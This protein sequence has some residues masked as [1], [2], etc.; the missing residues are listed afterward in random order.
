LEIVDSRR[1][2][3]LAFALTF[4]CCLPLHAAIEVSLEPGTP[5]DSLQ[6]ARDQVRALRKAGQ[7][8]HASIWVEH[9]IFQ[10]T[11]TVTFEAQDSDI[12]IRAVDSATPTFVGAAVVTGFTPHEG[13]IM[14]ADICALVAKGAKYRQVLFGGERL[15]LAR[16]PNFDA[17]DPLYGGWAF[18]EDIPKT[19]LEKHSWKTELYVKPQ[20]LRT[21][22]HPEEVE[23]DIFA[24]YGWWNFI[25][26]VKSLDAT[27]RKLTLA[28]PC[29][30]DLHPHNRFHFQNA[31]E[32]LDAP[33]EF[34]IDPRSSILYIM[35]PEE[36]TKREVRLVT[37][38]SFIKFSADAKNI[39]IERLKFTGCNS[40]AVTM[41]N[42]KGCRIAGC[43]FINVGDFNGSAIGISGGYDNTA[44]GNDISYT[45]SN[46]IS[47]SGG[48]RPTLTACNNTA[49]NNHIHHIGVFNKNA[50]GVSANGVGIT[51]SH[52]LIHH[53][54]RMGVQM[55]GNNIT[56]E[57]NHMHHLVLETQDGGAVYTGGRDWIGSRGSKWQYNHIHDIIGCGQEAGGLKHP[58]FSF[59]LYP[60]DNT[61]GVDI[62]GNLVYRCAHTPIHMHNSRDCIVENNIFAFGGKFQFDLHGW[63][64]DQ[65]YWIDHGPTM[66]KGYESVVNQPAWQSMRGMDID[67]RNAFHD[68]GTMMSGDIVRRNIMYSNQPGVKYGDLRNVS[69]R[70]NT[71]DENLAWNGG[72]PIVTGI[73]KVGADMGEPLVVE[74]F[75]AAEAGKTPKGWGFNHRPE[76]VQLVVNDGALRAD[77]KVTTD[78]KNPKTVFHGP[79]IPIKP[80]AAYRVKLRVRSTEE[81]SRIGLSL[82]SFENGKG[83]W[84][85]NVTSI[86][87]NKEWQA[88][89][90]TGRMP[91]EGDA[92][93]KPWMK[94]FWLR[95]DCHGETGQ[96]FI[97]DVRITEAAPLDEW[98]AWQAAGWDNKSIVADPL[99]MDVDNDDFRLKADSPAIKQLGFKPLPIEKMGLYES[100]LRASWPVN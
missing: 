65:H 43:T 87:A 21:W 27:T 89:E 58:W 7:T 69:P 23:L 82:A 34:Y 57:Y 42:A 91:L 95:V 15:L 98:A 46:G 71:I 20:D 94:D 52:N 19:A 80:G 30:Y 53:G 67:P 99:F 54:P 39:S 22:A 45:G 28:K 48:D 32:E 70:W 73:N 59:G 68:D 8:G 55:G 4:L 100:E 90:T 13:K 10:Q 72:H 62:I 93:W 85:T 18:V 61:G 56:V 33:G 74:T 41:T 37:L 76:G 11:K 44:V 66:I 25:Q 31:L 83:Y 26:P 35:P 64:K 81:S 49:D 51:I 84:A 60:D 9:G 96:I 2:M 78:P 92:N 36:I 88:V 38:D 14:K 16:W 75:D 86:N 63:T 40:T 79:D 5:L 77:C 1:A 97:D 47:L 12:T 3:R 6:A 17:N 50:C 24:Q 29:S